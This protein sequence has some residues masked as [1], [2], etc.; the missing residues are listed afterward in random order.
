VLQAF[1]PLNLSWIRIGGL[2][3]IRL[4]VEGV[5]RIYPDDRKYTYAK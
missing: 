3:A 1:A 5:E 2:T 4:L